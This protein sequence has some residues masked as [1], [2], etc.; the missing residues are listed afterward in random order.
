MPL[1]NTG[2][3]AILNSGKAGVTHVGALTDISTT[4][5]TGGSYARQ[6]VTWAAAG[7]PAAGQSGNT[8]ALTIPIPAGTTVQALGLYDALSA[9]N[10]LGIVP[11]GSAGQLVDG[12]ATVDVAD[13]FTSTAH[14]LTTDDRVF[15]S[16]IT[17]DALPT[18]ISATTLYFV[19]ASG[20]TANAF[21]VSTTSAGTALDITVASE[22]A[23]WK[24]V[25]NT[26]ASAGN[27]TVAISSIV[28]DATVI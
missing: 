9:G 4:E 11:Y 12:V 25:P 22:V 8:G 17:G 21:K 19:L 5:V 6:P 23:F 27:L 2:R 14:G 10:L 7:T 26:F 3:N 15:F 13:L 16:A 1:N 24:T 20:L 28:L 18:G